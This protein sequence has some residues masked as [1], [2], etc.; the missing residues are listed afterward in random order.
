MNTWLLE[1]LRCPGCRGVLELRARAWSRRRDDVETGGLRCAGCRLEYAIERGVA[2]FLSSS[3]ADLPSVTQRTRRVYDYTWRRFGDVAV[4]DA[5]EKDSYTF[6]AMIPTTLYASKD[7]LGL[8]AGCGAGH[9][10][11]RLAASG[12]RLVGFDLSAGV[13]TA[14]ALTADLPNVDVVQGD[15]NR[16]PFEDGVFDFVYSFGVL[17]HL[18][19]PRRGFSNLAALLKPGAPLITYLYEDFGDRTPLE[20]AALSA[21]R[22]VRRLTS[23][24]P[25]RVLH[26]LCWVF[27]P[28]VWASCSMPARLLTRVAPPLAARIPF[29]HTLRWPVLASDLFDRFAPPVEFRY[30]AA[31]VR[32]LY[33]DAG[34]TGIET[35]RHRGWVSWGYR[36]ALAGAGREVNA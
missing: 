29:R 34:L 27:T 5:W 8:D 22:F 36:P 26:A 30:S 14:R 25:A 33:E 17:H 35:R 20:R 23:R 15:L 12:A 18:P 10:L 7:K 1:V 3:D 11:Q 19:D 9:D 31:G 16:P 21:I 6:T 28:L 13:D 2:R 32:G 4:T 24:L